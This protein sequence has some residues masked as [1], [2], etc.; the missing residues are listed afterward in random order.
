MLSDN[1][2][3]LASH[4]PKQDLFFKKLQF[5]R[6]KLPSNN[7]VPIIAHYSEYDQEHKVLKLANESLLSYRTEKETYELI[8]EGEEDKE[9]G[10]KKYLKFLNEK[11]ALFLNY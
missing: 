7:N 8:M 3:F 10:E 2:L 9:A 4:K 1:D 11:M 5:I 6:N